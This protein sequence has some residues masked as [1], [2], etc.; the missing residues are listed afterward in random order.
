MRN[1]G[2]IMVVAAV[3][4]A[5]A[6]CSPPGQQPSDLPPGAEPSPTAAAPSQSPASAAPGSGQERACTVD[7]ITVTGGDSSSAPRVEIPRDCAAPTELLTKDLKQGN[8]P[9]ASPGSTVELE[10]ELVGWSDGQVKENTYDQQ[11]S[12]TV[13]LDQPQEFQGWDQALAGVKQGDQRLIVVP[14]GLGYGQDN[15]LANEPVV[16][17]ADVTHVASPAQ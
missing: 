12:L 1:A 7:D 8:G 13:R 14:A 5:L 3:A 17:V 4:T 6:A 2:K 16:V 15:P 11:S 10:Y 9:V